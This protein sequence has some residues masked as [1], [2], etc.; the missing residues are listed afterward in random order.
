MIP[1]RHPKTTR[2]LGAPKGWNAETDG[3]CGHLSICDDRGMMLSRWEPTPDELAVL[4][5]GGAVELAVV[6]HAHPPVSLI[7]VRCDQ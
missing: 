6:G 4:N 3:P 1:K 5:A 7:V 2:Y